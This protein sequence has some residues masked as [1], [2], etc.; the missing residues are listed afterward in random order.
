[1]KFLSKTVGSNTKIL[2]QLP[3]YTPTTIRNFKFKNNS[4]K[5]IKPVERYAWSLY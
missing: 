5:S 1:M 4:Y 2:T 3:F